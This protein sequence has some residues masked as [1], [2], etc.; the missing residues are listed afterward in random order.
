MPPGEPPAHHGLLLEHSLPAWERQRR[1]GTVFRDSNGGGL[2]E[3]GASASI[4]MP[5]GLRALAAEPSRP[6][7]LVHSELFVRSTLPS[8][9][10][11]DRTSCTAT[12]NPSVRDVVQSGHYCQPCD[13]A[14][15]S[16]HV[17]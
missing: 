6:L 10:Q 5:A 7:S 9:R 1:R 16:I 14:S 12:S 4:S 17:I 8:L 13:V 15:R 3:V 11:E 2:K